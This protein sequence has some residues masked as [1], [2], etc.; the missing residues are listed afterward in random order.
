MGW[1]STEVV[2]L[3]FEALLSTVLSG[4]YSQG[5]IHRKALN[6]A[7]SAH[8]KTTEAIDAARQ[9][10]KSGGYTDS[11]ELACLR[12]KQHGVSDTPPREQ[13]RLPRRER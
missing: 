6:G 12:F 3:S 1:L 4:S 9:C 5:L 13:A 7:N 2:F 11:W 8:G 10:E